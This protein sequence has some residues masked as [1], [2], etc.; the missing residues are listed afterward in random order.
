MMKL[1]TVDELD[2]NVENGV[3]LLAEYIQRLN[4]G[5][6]VDILSRKKLLELLCK[7]NAEEGDGWDDEKTIT[8]GSNPV[9]VCVDRSIAAMLEMNDA[10]RQRCQAGDL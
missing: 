3:V 10:S 8:L 6:Q 5:V 1:K 4:P 9:M 7:E 2:D